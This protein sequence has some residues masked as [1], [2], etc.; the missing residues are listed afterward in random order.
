[1]RN[2]TKFK[3]IKAA[4]DWHDIGSWSAI[5]QLAEKD[6][7]GNASQGE[8][9]WYHAHNNYVFN[10]NKGKLTTVLGLHNVI[11]VD[12]PDAL[13]VANTQ[14]DQAVK[15]IVE[16]LTQTQHPA[17]FLHFLFPLQRGWF[18]WVQFI[19]AVPY[20]KNIEFLAFGVIP[21]VNNLTYLS[22]KR[23]TSSF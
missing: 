6:D 3:V 17:S 8:T 16:H 23:E 22:G 19:L 7:N 14:Y 12:T 4:F 9:L 15:E 5:Q 20:P 10:D 11:V 18:H 2:T 21:V 1:M 13:L